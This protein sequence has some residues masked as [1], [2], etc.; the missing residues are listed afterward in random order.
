MKPF[1]RTIALLVSG[2]CAATAST[3]LAIIPVLPDY[4]Y[5]FTANPGQPTDVNGS[6]ITLQ[7]DTLVSW[8]LIDTTA[9]GG[10]AAVTPANSTVIV[11][12][13]TGSSGSAWAGSFDIASPF[14]PGLDVASFEGSNYLSGGPGSGALDAT[15]TPPLETT[16]VN[17]PGGIWT[18][19][20]AVVATPDAESS[21]DLLA[22]AVGTLCAGRLV[23][24]A[25]KN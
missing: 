22:V 9:P 14:N 15:Y 18:P 2:F 23:L 19:F 16:I 25:R 12:D 3:A 11:D 5:T 1:N 6:T 8:D 21:F 17:D 7:G 4:T 13:I 20:V 10:F 24:L